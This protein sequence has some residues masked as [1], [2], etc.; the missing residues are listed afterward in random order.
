MKMSL[1]ENVEKTTK[2][3]VNYFKNQALAKKDEFQSK[4][5][6]KL[7]KVSDKKDEIQSKTISKKNEIQSQ[8][9]DKFEESKGDLEETKHSLQRA[10]T[11]GLGN[12]QEHLKEWKDKAVTSVRR[13]PWLYALGGIATAGSL[14]LI[15][16]YFKN[17]SE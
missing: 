8:V 12:A 1:L 10:V 2:D 17:K 7:D 3:D 13:D 4:V 6:D 16:S 11:D 15:Y 14:Y 5:A 9:K